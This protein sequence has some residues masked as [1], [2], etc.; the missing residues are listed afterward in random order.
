MAKAQLDTQAVYMPPRGMPLAQIPNFQGYPCTIIGVGPTNRV[1]A[2]VKAPAGTGPY[3]S[4]TVENVPYCDGD[5]SPAQVPING[6]YVAPVGFLPPSYTPPAT[7][8]Q[9]AQTILPETIWANRNTTPSTTELNTP[10]TVP[11]P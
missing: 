5:V 8:N 1:S 6:G 4:Y 11:L 9:A 7:T 10:N 2:V 3:T